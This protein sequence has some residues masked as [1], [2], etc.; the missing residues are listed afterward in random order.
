MDGRQT[1]GPLSAQV[2]NNLQLPIDSIEAQQLSQ[3]IFAALERNVLFMSAALP[4][5]V[6]APRFNCH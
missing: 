2:K 3:T 6:L 5:R 1:A 4:R